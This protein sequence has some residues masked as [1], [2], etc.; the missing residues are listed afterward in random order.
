MRALTPSRWTTDVF[1]SEDPNDMV[2]EFLI[3]SSRLRTYSIS[4]TT[5]EHSCLNIDIII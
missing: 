5:R 1:T 2:M 3:K 4:Y